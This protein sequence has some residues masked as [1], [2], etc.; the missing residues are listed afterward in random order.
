MWLQ[1]HVAHSIKFGHKSAA[2]NWST[3]KWFYV[4]LHLQSRTAFCREFMTCACTLLG[5]LPFCVQ[6][7]GEAQDNDYNV[8]FSHNGQVM[9]GDV[10]SFLLQ[11]MCLTCIKRSTQQKLT[12]IN[13]LTVLWKIESLSRHEADV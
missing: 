8:G 5:T 9:T 12:I 2:W 7:V 11:T 6:H 10:D 4:N 13:S 1:I 3:T